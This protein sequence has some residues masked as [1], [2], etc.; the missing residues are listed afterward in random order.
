MATRAASCSARFFAAASPLPH[1]GA[2]EADLHLELLGVIRA[3]LAGELVLD[4]L[5][6]FLLDQLLELGL[7]VHIPRMLRRD[8]RQDKPVNQTGGGRKPPVQIGSRQHGLHCIGQDAL[9]GAAAPC[10]SPWPR[11]R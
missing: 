9:P 1:H 6:L 4:N 7:I 8:V 11:R 5:V 2:V 10:S 3:G